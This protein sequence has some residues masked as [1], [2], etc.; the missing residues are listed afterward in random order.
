MVS[1]AL[2]GC[3]ADASGCHAVFLLCSPLLAQPSGPPSQPYQALRS[4][5]RLAPISQALPMGSSYF[6]APRPHDIN[7]PSSVSTSF[8]ASIGQHTRATTAI[9]SGAG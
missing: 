2:I 5:Q 9:L 3:P 4:F 7:E 6:Q 8:P 1:H